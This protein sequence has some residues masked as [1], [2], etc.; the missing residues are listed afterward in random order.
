LF[1]FQNMLGIGS[2]I[3]TGSKSPW[4]AASPI[5]KLPAAH[6]DTCGKPNFHQHLAVK[7]EEI[8]ASRTLKEH[9]QQAERLFAEMDFDE[10]LDVYE[11]MA[12]S[13]KE[14]GDRA[15]EAV[16]VLGLADCLAKKDKVDVDLI[17]GMY[18]YAGD[19]AEESRDAEVRFKALTGCAKIRWSCRMFDRSE[20]LWQ[21]AVD[22]A[23]STGHREHSGFAKSQL[24]KAL[25]QDHVEVVDE[26]KSEAHVSTDTEE[27]QLRSGSSPKF[28]RALKLLEEVVAELPDSASTAQQ[29]C[30]RVNLASALR[31]KGKKQSTRS[32]ENQLGL[33]LDC[34]TA[35]GGHPEMRRTVEASHSELYEEYSWLL[36]GKPDSQKRFAYLKA[37]REA[38]RGRQTDVLEVKAIMGKPVDP[39]ERYVYEKATWANEKLE[40]M[41]KASSDDDSDSDIDVGPVRPPGDGWQR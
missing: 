26:S 19:A 18:R 6:T 35:A 16:A 9:R 12:T 23:V 21:A 1:Q 29:V 20:K 10:A 11:R 22:L 38:S 14:L 13:A 17:C 33:A 8:A 4:I 24:A 36:Y 28:E 27:P 5:T 31:T 7:S 15:S 30:A 25:L 32:A 41:T 3:I 34:M 40:A 37:E 2:Q 39:E